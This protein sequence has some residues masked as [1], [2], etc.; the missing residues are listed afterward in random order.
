MLPWNP[1]LF[2]K[3]TKSMRDKLQRLCLNK[4]FVYMFP[5]TCH[6]FTTLTNSQENLL[7][8]NYNKL[9]CFRKEKNFLKKF[10]SS[11]ANLADIIPNRKLCA[12]VNSP[13][14]I[15]FIGALRLTF[16]QHAIDNIVTIITANATQNISGCLC[17]HSWVGLWNTNN[18][19][20]PNVTRSWT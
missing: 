17:T 16:V 9:R 7:V 12:N 4:Y 11:M 1:I 5:Y 15:K 6:I 10:T 2:E 19:I 3:R 13:K 14:K 18:A 8:N 20:M